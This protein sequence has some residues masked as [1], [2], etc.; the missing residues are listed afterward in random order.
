MNPELRAHG[1]SFLA[2]NIPS[3]RPDL[4]PFGDADAVQPTHMH[5]AYMFIVQRQ[6]SLPGA[7]VDPLHREYGLRPGR[8]RPEAPRSAKSAA[9]Q[10]VAAAGLLRLPAQHPRRAKAV[11]PRS[12]AWP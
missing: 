10:I 4:C 6:D 9:D 2:F 7:A 12:A 8:V 3:I 1:N 5:I 11:V